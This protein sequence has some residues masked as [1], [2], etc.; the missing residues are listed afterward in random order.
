[1][2]NIP[3]SNSLLLPHELA[4]ALNVSVSWVRTHSAPSAKD[5]LPVMK[6]GGF[7]RYDLTEVLEWISQRSNGRRKE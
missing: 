6:V 7:L 2:S 5:R 3:S 4:K 1:M